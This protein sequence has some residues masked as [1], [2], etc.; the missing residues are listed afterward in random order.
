M[1]HARAVLLQAVA[2]S[3]H[4]NSS[5]AGD[6]AAIIWQE[7]LVVT[8]LFLAVVPLA[9]HIPA[10]SL[11][12][13]RMWV[14][15][16]HFC[17]QRHGPL[18]MVATQIWHGFLACPFVPNNICNLG[19]LRPVP[20]DSGQKYLQYDPKF[21]NDLRHMLRKPPRK[22]WTLQNFRQ[23]KSGEE[24]KQHPEILRWPLGLTAPSKFLMQHGTAAS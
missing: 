14:R 1:L 12:R 6:C 17:L 4:A 7:C 13:I 23:N 11:R 3:L 15:I 9:W 24:K 18:W 10:G 22:A 16:L 19:G 20:L 2:G 21:P 5:S 8:A